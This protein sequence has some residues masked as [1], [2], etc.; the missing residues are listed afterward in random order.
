[1]TTPDF[2]TAISVHQT[3]KEVFDGINHITGWWSEDFEGSAQ[4]LNDTF[5]VRFGET[6]ITIQVTELIT[7]RKIGWRV[8]DGY[9]H[10]LRNKKEWHNT[11]M[12]WEIFAEKD[13]TKISF[14]HI[15]LVPGLECYGGCEKAWNFYIKESLF[16][17]LTEGKGTP[18][19]KVKQGLSA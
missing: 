3:P 18:E 15:G 17:L 5:T 14:T 8:T 6:F 1:M 7:D 12:T 19:L 9:K 2:S 10:W 16:K 13:T 11:K 4:E